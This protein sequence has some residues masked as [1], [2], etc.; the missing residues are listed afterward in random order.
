MHYLLLSLIETLSITPVLQARELKLGKGN[1][2]LKDMQLITGRVETEPRCVSPS[3]SDTVASQ[4]RPECLDKA[5]HPGQAE[6]SSS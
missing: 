1:D 3:S 5:G 6:V 2:L 4:P